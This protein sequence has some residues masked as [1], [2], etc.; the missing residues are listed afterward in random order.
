V[1]VILDDL[2]EATRLILRGQCQK[3]HDTYVSLSGDAVKPEC[4]SRS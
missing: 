4:V 3:V 2:E 1:P